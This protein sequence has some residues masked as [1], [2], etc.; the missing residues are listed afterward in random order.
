MKMNNDKCQHLL[1]SGNKHEQNGMIIRSETISESNFIHL[2][3]MILDYDIQ[4]EKHLWWVYKKVN[5][6]KCF[7]K[8]SK[9]PKYLKKKLIFKESVRSL[10]IPE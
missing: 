8:E 10:F 9:I 5:K 4:F 6:N 2:L 7:V 1:I 3:V